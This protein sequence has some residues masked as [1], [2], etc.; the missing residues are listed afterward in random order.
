MSMAPAKLASV[1]RPNRL[2][3]SPNRNVAVTTTEPPR[4]FF[5]SSATWKPLVSVMRF[6]RLSMF[7]GDGSNASP[8]ATTASPL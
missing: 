8:A 6:A 5:G 3:S 1:A 7:S 4:V 2:F